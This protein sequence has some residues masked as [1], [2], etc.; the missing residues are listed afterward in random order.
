MP[1][2]MDVKAVEL[3][4]ELVKVQSMAQG[5][6]RVTLDIPGHLAEQASWLM[7]QAARTGTL[8]RVVIAEETNEADYGL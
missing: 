1:R 4:C 5:Q 8:Y 7:K 3:V 2:C 6:Y